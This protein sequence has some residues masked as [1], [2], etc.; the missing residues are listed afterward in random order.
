MQKI[1]ISL[2]YPCVCSLSLQAGEKEVPNIILI[3]IDDLGWS[4]LSFQGSK[5]YETPNI[6]RLRQQGLFFPNA[7]ACAANSAPSRAC[8]ISGMY[9]PRHGIYTVNPPDRGRAEKRKLI[10][11]P[12]TE[13]LPDQVI[14]LA[15]S[16][17]AVGYTTCHIG[18][19]HL[20]DDPLTQGMEVNIGGCMQGHPK[21][22]F[23]PYHNPSLKDGKAGEF[24]TD[25]LTT[26]AISYL[27][28]Q[29]TGKPFFLYFATYAVHTPLQAPGSLIEKYKNKTSDTAHNNPE[30]AALIEN[31]DRN[32]GRLMM[33]VD[34]LSLSNNCLIILTS[35][36][37]G[38]YNISRQWPLR[39]GKGSFY[40]GGIRVPLIVRWAGITPENATCRQTVS[41][42]D[43]YP[44]LMELTG[45]LVDD[46]P[47][48]GTNI[49]P[50]FKGQP[51]N[52]EE[53]S[54][55]WHFPAYLERG[56]E[57]TTD[58]VF[59]S[60]PLSVIRKGDWKLIRN[61]ETGTIELYNIHDDI[62]EKR[63]L[64]A[65]EKLTV[66]RLTQELDQWLKN[67]KAPIPTQ[68]NPKYQMDKQ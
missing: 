68:L 29:K 24:L 44:T 65:R 27:K 4:D 1:L 52:L 28:K 60:R 10:S 47:L 17:K 64:A 54:L 32:I 31:M 19:W 3:N 6:D 45:Y 57:E 43:L 38:V 34:S 9:S 66:A 26:E 21:S 16:L 49:L 30:Y 14:T 20:G 41:Q 59:R 58:R 5:Y 12:N 23:A 15:E 55:F 7:Y 40:E 46:Q 22:Y 50:L 61:I 48:D 36:N 53:R 67:T 35:D 39:A 42:I 13:I 25:R 2:L 18:K 37:G 62:S 56:N 33:A 51:Q 11:C 8:M 63:N